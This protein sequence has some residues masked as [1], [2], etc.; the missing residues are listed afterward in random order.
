MFSKFDIF[1]TFIIFA[2]FVGVFLTFSDRIIKVIEQINS[3]H[4]LNLVFLINEAFGSWRNVPDFA[5]ILNFFAFLFPTYPT[6]LREKIN[7]YTSELGYPWLI[8]TFNY[9]SAMISTLGIFQSLIIITFSTIFFVRKYKYFDYKY[10]Y[11]VLIYSVI[12]GFFIL[13]KGAI[14]FWLILSNGLINLNL[15]KKSEISN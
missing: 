1:N 11:L 5:I 14:I 15:R 12:I 6:N 3:I 8:S 9:F 2:S 13:P 7:L 4:S 10:N